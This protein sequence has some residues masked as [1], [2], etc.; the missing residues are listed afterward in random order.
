M[1]GIWMSDTGRRL[2]ALPPVLL[3][4]AAGGCSDQPTAYE[5]MAG[6]W[7]AQKFLVRTVGQPE[8]NNLLEFG[9]T[10]SVTLSQDGSAHW[11]QQNLIYG[12]N[13]DVEGVWE[14][15]RSAARLQFG[16]AGAMLTDMDFKLEERGL[17]RY[18]ATVSSDA[19]PTVQ[20][21]IE[22]IR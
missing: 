5:Q 7:T 17:L 21:T 19:A 9:G 15:S 18:E 16:G 14:A 20:V 22:L 8:P 12:I 6:T 2:R 10:L 13:L 1:S 3:W 11:R 4:I